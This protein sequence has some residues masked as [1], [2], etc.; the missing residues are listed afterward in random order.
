MHLD[1]LA[2]Q[3]SEAA[4]RRGL[5]Y[6]R[7]GAVTIKQASAT[8]IRAVASGAEDYDVCIAVDDKTLVLSCSCPAFDNE[9]PCKHLWAT[10]L[11]AA[12]RRILAVMPAW[13]KVEFAGVRPDDDDSV[14]DPVVLDGE[15]DEDPHEAAAAPARVIRRHPALSQLP[16]RSGGDEE[17]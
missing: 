16:L 2:R 12:E 8:A 11:V 4:R 5:A 14:D 13:T 1:D 17:S 6:Q 15:D 9:G 3:F 10:A 7:A